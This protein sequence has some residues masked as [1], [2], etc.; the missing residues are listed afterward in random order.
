MSSR[1]KSKDINEDTQVGD[2]SPFP[3]REE[4]FDFEPS[5][6]GD[7]DEAPIGD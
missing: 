7:Y 5:E 3:H 2:T 1:D 4:R 6:K